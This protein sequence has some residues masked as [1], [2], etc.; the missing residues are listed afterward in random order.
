MTQHVNALEI[1]LVFRSHSFERRVEELEI[2]ISDLAGRLLPTVKFSARVRY[3]N[4]AGNTLHID[5]HG[6]RPE[7]VNAKPSCCALRIATVPVKHKHDWSSSATYW[8]RV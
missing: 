2:A 6:F 4:D 1:N 3:T 5:N 7:L 8:R